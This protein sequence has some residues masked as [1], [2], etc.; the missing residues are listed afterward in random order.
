VGQVTAAE[1][2]DAFQG[3]SRRLAAALA[4]APEAAFAR[5]SP[6]PPWTVRE[7]L[8]HVSN[9]A[10]RVPGMLAQPEPPA[11]ELVAAAAYYRADRRFSAEVN[12][13]RV[14]DA[15]RGAAGRS[16]AD[17]RAGF[18]YA[19]S[20]AA[21][22]AAAAPPGRRV[23]TRHGDVMLLAE[24]MRTRVLEV[25]VHGLDLA[26]GLGR[27]PWLTPAAA[28]VIEDLV[29]A[30]G[31]GA[32]LGQALGWDQATLIAKVTGRQPVSPAERAAADARGLRWLALG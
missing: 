2:I 16:A 23:L 10:G 4:A 28:A 19:W 11:A 5:P 27:P 15:Q 17:L 20:A 21:A 29:L 32:A 9:A 31:A 12:A 1:V 6:C 22:A 18:D 3:E 13:G 26:G 8:W 7:L 24:F 30:P 14:D 25:A